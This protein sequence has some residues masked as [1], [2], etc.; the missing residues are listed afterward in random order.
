MDFFLRVRAC[1]S[2]DGCAHRYCCGPGCQQGCR[3]RQS[4]A[5][6][7]G[8]QDDPVFG[9]GLHILVRTELPSRRALS[10]V[11]RHVFAR[12][13]LRTRSRSRRDRSNAI[14][15]PAAWRRRSTALHRGA[16]GWPRHAQFSLGCWRGRTDTPRFRPGRGNR[17]ADH[18]LAPR[19]RP[20]DDGDLVYGQESVPSRRVRQRPEPDREDRN[21]DAESH[22]RGHPHRDDVCR[23]SNVCRRPVPDANR[24]AAGWLPNPRCHR[25]GRPA[26]CGSEPAGAACGR[27]P[28]GAGGRAARCT[29]CVVFDVVRPSRTASSSNFAITRS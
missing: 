3:R 13:R 4:R 9:H 8:P 11:P 22:P 18:Q 15:E 14:R 24:A 28:A 1:S 27:S 29:G 21:L 26:R 23:L 19:R 20:Y 7:D 10:E 12:H 17:V 16:R 5:R 25:D 2:R 6:C